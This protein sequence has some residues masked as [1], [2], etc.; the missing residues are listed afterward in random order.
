MLGAGPAQE[1]GRRGIVCGLLP[2]LRHDA[3]VEGW[4]AQ[5]AVWEAALRSD[6]VTA[7]QGALDALWR[8]LGF[9]GGAD[10]TRESPLPNLRGLSSNP[11][12]NGV[13]RCPQQRPCTRVVARTP[14][15][16][17]PTCVL[18]DGHAMRFG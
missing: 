7:Q 6:N 1:D 15:S 3:A 4:S 17:L 10:G 12:P 13:Y 2:E 14:G 8:R 16:P 5:L 18:L 11:P 9:A